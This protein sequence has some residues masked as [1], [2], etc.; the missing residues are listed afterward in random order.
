MFAPAFKGPLS[1][2]L[3][4]FPFVKSIDPY[5]MWLVSTGEIG[6][7]SLISLP[8]R[9]MTGDNLVS[10]SAV[11]SSPL[12]PVFE[13]IKSFAVFTPIS[14]LGLKFGKATDYNLCCTPQLFKNW[15]ADDEANSSP[16]SDAHSSGIH[17]VA[18][19]LRRLV[20]R[21]LVPS[22]AC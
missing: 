15:D 5:G 14:A 3:G 18:K 8:N 7:K 16:P 9:H 20:I 4:F 6:M 10:G 22:S 17:Y 19:I 12:G 1:I 2:S 11:L 21:P 13:D